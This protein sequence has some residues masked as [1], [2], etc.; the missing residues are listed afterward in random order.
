MNTLASVVPVLAVYEL[1]QS[2]PETPVAATGQAIALR[3][4][5]GAGS[6]QLNTVNMA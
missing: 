2:L 3:Y 6:G 4:D 5:V 1:D